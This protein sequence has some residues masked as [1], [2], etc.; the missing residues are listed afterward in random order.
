[1]FYLALVSGLRK[2]ELAALLW[3]DLDIANKTIFVSKQ[4]VRNPNGELTLS[5]PKTETSVRRVSIPQEAVDLLIQEHSKHPNNQYM[6]P[7]PATG[8]MYHP[9]SV[10]ILKDASLEHIPLYSL[11]HTFATVALQNGIDVKQYAGPLRR[12]LY[13]PYLHPC[14][15]ASSKSGSRNHG[16]FHGPGHVAKAKNINQ[17][18]GE[19]PIRTSPLRRGSSYSGSACGSNKN[20]KNQPTQNVPKTKQN[21]PKS[22]DF[23]GFLELLTRFELVTSSLP[24]AQNKYFHPKKEKIKNYGVQS[25]FAGSK[26]SFV[27]KMHFQN[28]SLQ[29]MLKSPCNLPDNDIQ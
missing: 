29:F 13:L 17:K 2:G 15:P 16:K 10:K 25:N 23:R 6:F 8:E 26:K 22:T 27:L 24:K 4:Y 3:T 12:R 18:R 28:I 20:R 9:D 19:V 5:H 1:M 11:R 14:H 21:P 7:S